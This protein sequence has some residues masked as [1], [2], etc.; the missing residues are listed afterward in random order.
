MRLLL[1]YTTL[2]VGVEQLRTV[3]MNI[4]QVSTIQ[5]CSVHVE[6]SLLQQMYTRLHYVVCQC[7]L[8]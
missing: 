7:V 8:Y 2:A 4:K 5:S 3:F 6:R 1:L